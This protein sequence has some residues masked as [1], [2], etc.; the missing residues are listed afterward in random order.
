MPNFP[1]SFLLNRDYGQLAVSILFIYV[2]YRLFSYR[3]QLPPGPKPL[4]V[5]GNAHQMPTLCPEETYQGWQKEYGDI[6][7]V[8]IF[9]SNMLILNAFQP[10]H[11]LL[12]KRSALYSDRPRFVLFNELMGWYNAST[13]VQYGPRF[14]KH[15]RFIHQTFNEQAARSLRPIQEREAL[16]LIR[17]LMESPE[18][19]SQHIRR[20][21]LS[22]ERA[23]SLTVQS[24]TPA[25]T[26][27]DFFPI[28]KYLPEWAPMAEFQRNARV[29]KQAVDDMM[30]VP[31]ETVRDQMKAGTV[32][33]CLTS[34]LLELFGESITFQD[35]EDIKGTTCVLLSFILAMVLHP[36]VF[37]E[38]QKEMDQ[39][40]GVGKLPTLEDRR[41]LPYLECVLKEVYRWNPPVPL[42]LPHRLM[43]DDIYNG[44]YI[45]K[46]ATILANIYAMLQGCSDPKTFRP[47]RYSEPESVLDC[48]DPQEVVFG[49]GRRRCPGRYFA[50]TG[51]WLVVANLIASTNIAKAQ[52][53]QRREITPEVEFKTGFVRHPQSF[54]CSITPRSDEMRNLIDK[55]CDSDGSA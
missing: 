25:S 44:Y 11:E 13:H 22:A 53:E 4:P 3:C 47:G 10:A 17:G 20:F 32:S 38:T 24:G 31:F 46:G 51:I 35:E 28:I 39:V 8:R 41:R 15:R 27:V 54:P 49:F 2:A 1:A 14:R 21:E 29:V 5:I 7:H 30:N 16:T 55:Y 19:Y 52:D 23:G 36:H 33:S 40:I 26:L 45:P 42:G 37:E 18:Q 50:D 9:G 12:E 43:Q 6:V 34:R 48:L